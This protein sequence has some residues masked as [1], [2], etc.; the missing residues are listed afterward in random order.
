MPLDTYSIPSPRPRTLYLAAQV[1][2]KSMNDLTKAIISI[3]EHDRLLEKLYPAY[4]VEYKVAPIEIYIDSYGGS[5]Y[6]C[7]GL[8]GVMNKSI[9]PI[10]TIATGAAMSCGFMILI[11]GHKRFGYTHSTPL[12]HQV[13]AGSW[14]KVKDLEENLD[15]TKKLQKKIEEITLERTN[16]SKKRLKEVLKNKVDWFMTAEEALTL[17][18][19]DGIL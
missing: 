12:Y 9:T 11:S 19:I 13:S 6:Q 14:G 15:Q 7:F 1:N 5:V 8:L 3:N 2:Q 18:V 4:N 17:G 10:H 16:I